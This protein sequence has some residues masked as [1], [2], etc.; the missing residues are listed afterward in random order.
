M[1]HG[2]ARWSKSVRRNWMWVAAILLRALIKLLKY[3]VKIK[4]RCVGK[5]YAF[6]ISEE[7]AVGL[8]DD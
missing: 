3:M 1:V 6:H 7:Q 5:L 4:F 2:G 8:A